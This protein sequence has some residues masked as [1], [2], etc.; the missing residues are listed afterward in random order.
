MTHRIA[1]DGIEFEDVV[2][3]VLSSDYRRWIYA[4]APVLVA[5]LTAAGFEETPVTLWVSAVAAVLAALLAIA[6]SLSSW[7]TALYSAVIVVQP[8]LVWYGIADNRVVTFVVFLVTAL[9]FGVAAANTPVGSGTVAPV[10]LPKLPVPPV[11]PRIEVPPA[12]TQAVDRVA[13]GA[14]PRVQ[15]IVDRVAPDVDL[16]YERAV[17]AIRKRAAEFGVR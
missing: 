10:L 6:N 12:V 15:E 3:R 7:R 5:L 14:G 8:L 17:E 1:L 13:P 16:A 4:A 2:D 9:G 11:L